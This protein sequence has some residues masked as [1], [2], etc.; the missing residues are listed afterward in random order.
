M[1]NLPLKYKLSNK[2]KVQI[3]KCSLISFRGQTFQNFKELHQMKVIKTMVVL[4]STGNGPAGLEFSS[5]QSRYKKVVSNRGLNY[6]AAAT[7]CSGGRFFC[8]A[9]L[10]Y[11]YSYRPQGRLMFSQVSVCSLAG[12]VWGVC[13]METH[14]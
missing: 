12:G 3:F 11:C 8:L 13:L 9:I 5:V 1:V 10:E 7:K 2:L 6:E 14:H 4:Y